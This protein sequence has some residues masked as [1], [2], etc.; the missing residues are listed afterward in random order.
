[1][2]AEQPTMQD[3]CGWRIL[4]IDPHLKRRLVLQQTLADLG[5]AT[6]LSASLEE[7][8][9]L[10]IGSPFDLIL[11]HPSIGPDLADAL[12]NLLRGSGIAVPIALMDSAP[13]PQSPAP[14]TWS[15]KYRWLKTPIERRAL[16]EL[17][18]QDREQGREQNRIQHNEATHGAELLGDE[19]PRLQQRFLDSLD[20]EYLTTIKQALEQSRDPEQRLQQRQQ[21]SDALHKLK[22]GAGSFGYPQ[23]GT[24][25]GDAESH[26]LRGCSVAAI[27]PTIE[28]LLT[29]AR[30]LR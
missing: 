11:M 6:G 28:Q 12:V 18:E 10:A 23:L 16:Q 7:A 25:A 9:S 21:L 20:A 1:M 29:L 26:L 15:S 24:L 14:G 4:V 8:L 13:W 22:G 5:I 30:G 27:R 3:R 19:M 17:I 2:D